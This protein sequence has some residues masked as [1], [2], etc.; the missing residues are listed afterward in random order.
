MLQEPQ[1][2][3]RNTFAFV[4]LLNIKAGGDASTGK[5]SNQG[6]YTYYSKGSKTMTTSSPYHKML[7]LRDL[8][9]NSGK[10]FYFV[11]DRRNNKC[12]FLKDTTM[13]DNGVI[14]IGT[15]FAL[16]NP[17]PVTKYMEDDIPLVITKN[18]LICLKSSELPEVVINHSISHNETTAFCMK[19]MQIEVLSMAPHETNCSGLFVIIKRQLIPQQRKKLRLLLNGP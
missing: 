5:T 18:S 6:N 8:S 13:R 3:Q 11:E 9:S 19:G 14:S 16:P 12:L 4:Q 2:K 17:Q 10:C 7:L 15:C 1:P